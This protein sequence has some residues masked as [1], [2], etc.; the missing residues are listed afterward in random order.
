MQGVEHALFANDACGAPIAWV[1]CCPWLFFD[2]KLFQMK[3]D[4]AERKRSLLEVCGG[5]VNFL[6]FSFLRQKFFYDDNLS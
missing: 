3:L 6:V 2:G 5:Q 4:I 1:M